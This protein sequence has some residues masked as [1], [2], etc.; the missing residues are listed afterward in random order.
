MTQDNNILAAASKNLLL[1]EL[2]GVGG[3]NSSATIKDA[4]RVLAEKYGGNERAFKGSENLLP[5]PHDEEYKE[6][7]SA[8]G[9]VRAAFYLVTMPYGST[10]DAKSGKT[11]AD[12]KRAI[13]ASKI[14]DG[15][16]LAQMQVLVEQLEQAR[17]KF[18]AVLPDRIAAIKA[19]SAL[20]SQ[21]DESR[22]PTTEQVLSSWYYDEILPEPILDAS[23]VKN[24]GLPPEVAQMIEEN[25]ARKVQA[26]VQFGQQQLVEETMKYVKTMVTN[27]T[28]LN[29]YFNG[30]HK[31]K[32]PS[33]FDSLVDNV[34]DSLDKLKTYALPGTTEGGAVLQLVAGIEQRLD[35]DDIEMSDLKNDGKVAEKVLSGAKEAAKLIDAWSGTSTVFDEPQQAP[36]APEPKVEA[37]PELDIDDL[38]DE[39]N[40]EEPKPQDLGTNPSEELAPATE[41]D[42]PNEIPPED[43]VLPDDDINDLLAGW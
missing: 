43:D 16:F 5:S 41:E 31:G 37:T 15:T 9:S 2:K 1:V 7:K 21:F 28:K 10:V 42:E 11:R 14:V 35:M 27:L 6:L 8:Y 18:A 25:L 30:Q 40:E 32:R 33:I 4:S 26:Q 12:G 29:A 23:A 3:W 38:L 24:M 22:Y 39:V 19:E 34:K 13:I 20:G 17:N 36:A